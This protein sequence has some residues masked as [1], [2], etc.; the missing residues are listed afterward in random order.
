MTIILVLV[1]ITLMI[2]AEHDKTDNGDVYIPLAIICGAVA[3]YSFYNGLA[4]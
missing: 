1:A 2:I 3:L 4:A